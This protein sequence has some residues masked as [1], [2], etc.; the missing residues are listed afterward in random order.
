MSVVKYRQWFRANSAVGVRDLHPELRIAEQPGIDVIMT[1]P[2]L[3]L[4]LVVSRGLQPEPVATQGLVHL[5]QTSAA[6]RKALEGLANA[7]APQV[8]LAGLVYA[9]EVSLKGE[10][11]G[12]PDIIG[13]DVKGARLVIEA[14]FDAALTP[15]QAGVGYKEWLPANTPA[16]L[17]YL[18][19]KNRI[20]S[21]WPRLMSG[22]GELHEVDPP[23]L[24]HQDEPWLQHDLGMGHVLALVSWESLLDRLKG[25]LADAQELSDF[26]QLESLVRAYLA[27][28]WVPLAHGDLLDRTGHQIVGLR[29]CVLEAVA[30]VSPSKVK[31]GSGDIGPGRWLAVDGIQAMWAGLH[32]TNWG[33]FGQSPIWAFAFE[34]DQ[35]EATKLRDALDPLVAK[36]G[37]GV[38]EM[39]GRT[40]GGSY[41][42]A[43]R[44]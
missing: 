12:R 15:A 23:D 41:F 30:E 20:A 9:G 14:K 43:S 38:F 34:K 25:S 16:V 39:N 2:S 33:R 7:I 21:I 6:A 10:Q 3:L 8:A 26:A 28:G 36:G 44:R 13:R 19:P 11:E 5:L 24:S 29:Q 31:P 1:S 37:P 18:V 42:C 27:S 32:L 35:V 17:I 22:P 40:W 4:N